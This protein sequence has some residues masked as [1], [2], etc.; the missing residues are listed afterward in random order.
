MRTGVVS[1]TEQSA[2]RHR[3]RPGKSESR[4][5]PAPAEER[6]SPVF[7]FG[8]PRSGTTLVDVILDSHPQIS[9]IEEQVKDEPSAT[10]RRID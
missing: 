6:P 1:I 3:V 9:T 4:A 10:L 8:F 5:N 2:A 7:M